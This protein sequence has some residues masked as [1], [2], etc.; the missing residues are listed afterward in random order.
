MKSVI[1]ARVELVL[2]FEMIL[3]FFMRLNLAILGG[4][5]GLLLITIV[6]LYGFPS[7]KTPF[8][9]ILPILILILLLTPIFNRSGR[10]IFGLG[11]FLRVTSGG[12]SDAIRYVLR[13]SGITFS[14]FLF[15]KTTEANDVLLA[16]QWFGLPF[17]IS[18]TITISLQYI[19]GLIRAYGEI[20]DAHRLRV[21]SMESSKRRNN[22]LDRFSGKRL[23]GMIPVLVAL[24]V[25]AVKR[26]PTLAMALEMRGFGRG[27]RRTSLLK[28]ETGKKF[29]LDSLLG[30]ILSAFLIIPIVVF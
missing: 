25:Y 19:P 14:V 29:L 4:Y 21:P 15:Y 5:F 12:L 22:I 11:R 2:L 24:V 30:V 1:D 9:G 26:I 16:F 10:M 6:I 23:K 8:L 17:R 18:L 3:L 13:L 7:I 27:E 28:L 20:M